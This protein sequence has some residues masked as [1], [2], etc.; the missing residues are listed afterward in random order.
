MGIYICIYYS[1]YLYYIRV[2]LLHNFLI[3]PFTRTPLTTASVWSALRRWRPAQWTSV[4]LAIP[5]TAGSWPDDWTL[6][7]RSSDLWGFQH[8]KMM[9]F[10]CG[11]SG[12]T[13]HRSS[14]IIIDHHH[15]PIP[16]WPQAVVDPCGAR[17]PGSPI[18]AP[19][20]NDPA[21]L[22]L[23]R[24]ISHPAAWSPPASAT[25]PPSEGRG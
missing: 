13:D 1:I 4:Y 19:A 11:I 21:A 15:L 9:I 22:A 14:Q 2:P 5:W 6:A 25:G 12:I 3:P 7:A 16:L 20:A 10:K 17:A 8:G 23:H 18:A 24:K